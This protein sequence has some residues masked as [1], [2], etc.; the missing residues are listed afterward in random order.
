M[1]PSILQ[2]RKKKYTGHTRPCLFV[3]PVF[4]VKA[5]FSPISLWTLSTSS[6][7][8]FKWEP[9]GPSVPPGVRWWPVQPRTGGTICSPSQVTRSQSWFSGGQSLQSKE[10]TGCAAVASAASASQWRDPT[11]G[12]PL[13]GR[14]L[15]VQPPGSLEMPL[16]SPL[17][18]AMSL[19][20]SSSSL[21]DLVP[22]L[23]IVQL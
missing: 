7:H 18:V 9:F 8:F 15:Q 11:S 23:Q 2:R 4:C 17:M 16:Q 5:F 21:F 13:T 12:C 6:S 14:E 19:F 10:E 20:T 22:W 3:H 1:Q